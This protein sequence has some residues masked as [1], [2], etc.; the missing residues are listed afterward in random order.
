MV[1]A[2]CLPKNAF[3][4]PNDPSAIFPQYAKPDLLDFRSHKMI[5]GGLTSANN[6]RKMYSANAKK[7]K[8]TP[9]VR[10]PEEIEADDLKETI[11]NQ[12][13]ALEKKQK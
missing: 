8:Y 3:L 12:A 11:R 6:F 2:F 5:G 13:L 1:E 9:V 7:S 4:H 10:L